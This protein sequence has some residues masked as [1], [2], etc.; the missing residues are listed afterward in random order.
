MR[1]AAAAMP[2]T[3]VTRRQMELLQTVYDYRE[4]H[5]CNATLREIAAAM[6]IS[7]P[8]VHE[9][10]Q[11]LVAKGL[12]LHAPGLSRS[13][14]LTPKA[15]AMVERRRPPL[16]ELLEAWDMASHQERRRFFKARIVEWKKGPGRRA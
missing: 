4:A 13:L 14:S 11:Y 15:R 2:D 10:G 7:K 3:Q 6:G 1:A 8:T 12:L 9:H 5:G 16:V